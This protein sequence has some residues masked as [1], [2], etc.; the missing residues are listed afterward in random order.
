MKTL[1][2]MLTTLPLAAG[3]TMLLIEAAPGEVAECVVRETSIPVIGCGAGP[4]C[5]G[6]IVVTQ[7]ILGLTDWQPAFARPIGSMGTDLVRN[8][9]RWVEMVRTSNLGEHPYVMTD[10]EAG[11]FLDGTR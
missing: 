6:Q 10:E 1:I 5:H 7:D 2:A 9:E 11:R 4:A 8:A 3:A